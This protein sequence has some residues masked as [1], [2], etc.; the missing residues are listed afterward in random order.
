MYS[1][2]RYTDEMKY[3]GAQSKNDLKYADTQKKDQNIISCQL[4]H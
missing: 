4:N 1:S 2:W 3:T